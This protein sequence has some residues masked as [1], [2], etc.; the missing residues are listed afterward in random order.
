MYY[1]CTQE[2]KSLRTTKNQKFRKC[3]SKQFL[4]N[5]NPLGVPTVAE[6]KQIQLGTM[7][8]WVRSLA[9]L[10]GLGI[11]HCELC[12]VVA[13][14]AQIPSCCGCDVGWKLWLRL[15]P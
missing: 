14:K 3:R 4:K 6:Q 7:R 13:D 11:Q 2:N 1:A 9:S 15:D 10:S 5:N 12:G 8:F